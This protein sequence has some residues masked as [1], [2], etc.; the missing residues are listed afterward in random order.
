MTGDPGR[1]TDADLRRLGALAVLPK[2]FTADDLACV[3]PP[4]G[5]RGL[6]S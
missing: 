3:L 5:T 4:L 1:W 2:P 6:S